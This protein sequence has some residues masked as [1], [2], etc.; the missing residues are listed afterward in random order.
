L[1]VSLKFCIFSYF[2]LYYKL[3]VDNS[4]ISNTGDK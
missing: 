4:I 3:I 1:R 2:R